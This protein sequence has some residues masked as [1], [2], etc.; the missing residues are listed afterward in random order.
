M[1]TRSRSEDVGVFSRLARLCLGV[2]LSL[3]GDVI[4]PSRPL[5]MVL[6]NGCR[7]FL[8]TLRSR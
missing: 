3:I 4:Q 6:F 5:P 7:A 2:S 1:A 8:L